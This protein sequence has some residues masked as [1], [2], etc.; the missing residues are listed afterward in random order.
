MVL[1]VSLYDQQDANSNH[2]SYA[3]NGEEL[4]GLSDASRVPYSNRDRD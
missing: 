3:F 2:G 4:D 1:A